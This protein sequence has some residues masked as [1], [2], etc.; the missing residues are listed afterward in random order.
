MQY[1]KEQRAAANRT[2]LYEFLISHHPDQFK[3]E[4]MRYLRFKNDHSVIIGKGFSGF[5]DCA[6]D[7]GGNNI[8]FLMQYLGYDLVGAIVALSGGDYSCTENSVHR[9]PKIE[10]PE[11]TN[12]IIP[13]SV[14]GSYKRLYA[15]LLSRKIKP[16]TI[17]MLIDQKL[18]YEEAE[19]HNIVFL[20][21]ARTWGEVHGTLSYKSHHGVLPNSQHGGF[22][23]FQVG[24]K[25]KCK[26]VY[27]CEAAIDAISLYELHR[28]RN[29]FD[30]NVYVSIGGAGKQEPIEFL[31]KHYHV[32][33]ATD[34]DDAGQNTRDRNSELEFII[35][36][37][38]DWNEDLQNIKAPE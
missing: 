26:N 34:N 29:E 13:D 9:N 17:Q 1:T 30:D 15:Y 32:I 25:E 37:Y 19:Y 35:P 12:I 6:T 33:I 31:K 23:F 27:V 20:N 38:K 22:W 8:D 18:I 4:G 28:I 11:D 3:K 2:D 24:N 10:K 14:Q 36:E 21:K 7:Q 5:K 16:D